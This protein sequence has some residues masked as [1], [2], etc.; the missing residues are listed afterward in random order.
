[1]SVKFVC[2]NSKCKKQEWA[3]QSAKG[4]TVP[5]K[6]LVRVPAKGKEELHACSKK[7]AKLIYQKEKN[8]TKS[9]TP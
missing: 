4:I 1:M 9:T 6:W 7:C 5:N 3:Q 2:D 8:E